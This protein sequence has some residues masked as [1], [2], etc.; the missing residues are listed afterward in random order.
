MS[1]TGGFIASMTLMVGIKSSDIQYLEP[2]MVVTGDKPPKKLWVIGVDAPKI[3]ALQHLLQTA[4]KISNP[5]EVESKRKIA[6]HAT[7]GAVSIEGETQEG[8]VAPLLN[9]TSQSVQLFTKK[10]DKEPM[11]SIP[12]SGV[13]RTAAGKPLDLGIDRSMKD[14]KI[15]VVSAQSHIALDTPLPAKYDVKANVIVDPYSARLL[16][17]THAGRIYVLPSDPE[18][19]VLD[20]KGNLKGVLR[21]ELYRGAWF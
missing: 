11:V 1:K 16:R 14:T 13:I 19:V 7:L 10:D 5:A 12:S 18:N 9:F 15:S 6:L 4:R 8:P 3:E 2:Y 20:E 21:L 17:S